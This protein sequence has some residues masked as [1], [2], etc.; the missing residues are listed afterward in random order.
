MRPGP[1]SGDQASPAPVPSPETAGSPVGSKAR[2][3]GQLPARD[4][5]GCVMP[6]I[7]AQSMPSPR[8]VER[9]V[10]AQGP[11]AGTGPCPFRAGRAGR[12]AGAAT[13]SCCIP[14]R[15]SSAGLD[16]ADRPVPPRYDF[17]VVHTGVFR[18]PPEAGYQA[19]RRVN[20][21]R[22]PVIRTLIRTRSL[23][24]SLAGRRDAAPWCRSAPSWRPCPRPPGA[25]GTSRSRAGT[26]QRQAA[27]ADGSRSRDSHGFL[28]S[29]GPAEAHASTP[30]H[31]RR[32]EN[33]RTTASRATGIP[34]SLRSRR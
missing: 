7:G 8:P 27:C 30:E 21:F 6:R 20:L 1:G 4:A 28:S 34:L 22:A 2:P 11:W 5:G 32:S 31:F 10:T 3:A 19:A 9:A 26:L 12:A 24:G 25:A 13:G 15:W 33:L 14:R 29:C 17:A 23:A 18:A 16:A